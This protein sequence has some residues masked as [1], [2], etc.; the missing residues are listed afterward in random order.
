LTAPQ[1]IRCAAAGIFRD[2]HQA[3]DRWWTVTSP[4]GE[5][6]DLCSAC[7]LL[8]FAT[9]GALPATANSVQNSGDSASSE[10]AA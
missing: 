1:R 7:C 10:E 3:V 9:L 6:Y 4:T 2:R 5:T 8:E